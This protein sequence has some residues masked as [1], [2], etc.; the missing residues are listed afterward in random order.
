MSGDVRGILVGTDGSDVGK[1]AVDHAARLA[2]RHGVPLTIL[3]AHEFPYGYYSV[4][5]AIYP[6]TM[7][8][9]ERR[10]AT[11]FLTTETDRVRDEF[12]GI[13]EVHGLFVDGN[14][15]RALVENSS[16]AS[17][18]VVGSRGAG[19]FERLMV[20]AVSSQVA[21]HAEGVV[22]IVPGGDGRP[23]D[24]PVVVGSDGSAGAAGA[25]RFAIGEAL[26]RGATL[27]VARFHT[28]S[29][30]RGADDAAEEMAGLADWLSKEHP[31]LKA[32]TRAMPDASAAHGLAELS[33]DASLTVVGSRGRGGFAGLLLGSVSGTLLHNARGPVAVVHESARS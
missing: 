31:G 2:A 27:T 25:L 21:A 30:E 7:V 14:A 12:P 15:T 8:E 3:H 33:E 1:D 29:D 23:D 20:G 24:A 5:G 18:T 16:S 9:E 17:V 19:G 11:G 26:A 32:K 28:P 22:L 13:P 4:L 6:P 10:A